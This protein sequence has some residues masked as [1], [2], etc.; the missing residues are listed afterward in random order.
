MILKI[1]YL[2]FYK[3]VIHFQSMLEKT[4]EYYLKF[5]NQVFKP[6]TLKFLRIDDDKNSRTV[7]LVYNTKHPQS[8]ADFLTKEDLL[9]LGAEYVALPPTSGESPTLCG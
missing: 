2:H 1:P 5:E 9:L 4:N 3:N 8:K 7:D 6:K